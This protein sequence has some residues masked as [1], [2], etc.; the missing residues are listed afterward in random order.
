[1]Y[2]RPGDLAALRDELAIAPR[3]TL[4][5]WPGEGALTVEPHVESARLRGCTVSPLATAASLGECPRLLGC[6]THPGRGHAPSSSLQEAGT[7]LLGLAQGKGAGRRSTRSTMYL[8]SR[9]TYSSLGNHR[10]ASLVRLPP[11]PRV[12]P[13]PTPLTPPPPPSRRRRR[14]C[15]CSCST[16]S[17]TTPPPCSVTYASAAAR[18]RTWGCTRA[19]SRYTSM[20]KVPPWRCPR[21]CSAPA[22]PQGAPGSSG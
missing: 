10:P 5:L 22:P 19:P 17:T 1:M 3:H 7:R 20:V 21:C 18:R 13:P 2:G 8:R 9:P 6:S 4:L 12:P 11:R 14:C 15:G 16:A